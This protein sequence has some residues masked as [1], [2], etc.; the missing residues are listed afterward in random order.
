MK[1][2]WHDLPF[3]SD[4]RTTSINKILVHSYA[5]WK[6]KRE[7]RIFGVEREEDLCRAMAR[8]KISVRTRR[9]VSWR[10]EEGVERKRRKTEKRQTV[11]TESGQGR[12]EGNAMMENRREVGRP[13]KYEQTKCIRISLASVKTSDGASL[14][15]FLV[16][17]YRL[18]PSPGNSSS[19]RCVTINWIIESDWSEDRS[20]L[21]GALKCEILNSPEKGI[22]IL[23]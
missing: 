23:G 21:R 13:R 4:T 20:N 11:R 15:I 9:V 14:E 2:W 6:F 22:L 10:I 18:W 5:R 8:K 16:V 19:G 12:E 7:R 1:R 17:V 3:S